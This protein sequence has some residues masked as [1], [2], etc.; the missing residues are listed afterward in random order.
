M[1]FGS[2]FVFLAAAIALVL[3]ATNHAAAQKRTPP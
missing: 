2:W 1:R 3:M